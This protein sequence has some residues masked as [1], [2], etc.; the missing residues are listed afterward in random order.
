[1]SSGHPSLVYQE[2][3]PAFSILDWSLNP[4]L[5]WMEANWH[6][7]AYVSI[8]YMV[9]IYSLQQ[10]MRTRTP[11][12]LRR[13]L[14]L[15]NVGL[16]VFSAAGSYHMLG[17][18]Y[19][20]LVLRG[21]DHSVCVACTNGRA[22][23]WMWLFALSKIFELGDTVFIVLRKQRLI[24]LHW[25]HHILALVYTWYSFGQNISLGRWFVTMNYC[26]HSIMYGYYAFRALQV[27]VPRP[28]AMV[29]TSLQIVQMV[30]GFYVSSYAFAVK[31][32]GGYCDIPMKTATFGFLVYVTFFC[33]FANLFIDN[34]GL[35]KLLVG[36]GRN[37]GGGGG[38]E[39][40]VG[41]CVNGNGVEKTTMRNADG[42]ESKSTTTTTTSTTTKKDL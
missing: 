20:S 3:Q 33:L 13:T 34:Y 2:C 8:V 7:T 6:Y 19:E 22:Q 24:F 10:L 25:F 1:M 38:K 26:V 32:T 28:I 27:S 36:G 37:K 29:V 14:T 5:K 21:L 16:T 11:F 31:L 39:E 35:R 17:E 9:L 18:M 30:F 23:Y 12:K 4:S 41:K 15:W 42:E 40:V